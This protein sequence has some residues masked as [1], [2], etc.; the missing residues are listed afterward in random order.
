MQSVVFIIP[1][2]DNLDQ[3]THIYNPGTTLADTVIPQFRDA[4]AHEQ[5][6]FQTEAL[7]LCV[8]Q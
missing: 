7:E 1:L 8:R 3:I 4:S 2:M 6:G 5:F